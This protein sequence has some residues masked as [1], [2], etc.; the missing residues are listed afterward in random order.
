[1]AVLHN[2][3][4]QRDAVRPMSLAVAQA[5]GSIVSAT[6]PPT[7]VAALDVR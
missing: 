3:F 6:L 4:E 2:S 7:S 1:L 5:S